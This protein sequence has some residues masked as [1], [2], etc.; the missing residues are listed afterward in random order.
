MGAS[1]LV[2]AYL[3]LLLLIEVVHQVLKCRRDLQDT[4]QHWI[5][6]NA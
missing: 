6:L 1:Y 4:G 3:G 2:Y 5:R